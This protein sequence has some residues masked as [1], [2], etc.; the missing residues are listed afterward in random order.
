[1]VKVVGIVLLG[2]IGESAPG[3]NELGAKAPLGDGLAYSP[4]PRVGT[5]PPLEIGTL[6]TGDESA[7][8]RADVWKFPRSSTVS[9]RNGLQRNLAAFVAVWG[10]E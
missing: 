4:A 10:A 8:Y 3:S 7:M 9:S 6:T 5:A 2:V 1:M